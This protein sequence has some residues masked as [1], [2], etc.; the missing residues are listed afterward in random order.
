MTLTAQFILTTSN[1]SHD[2]TPRMAGPGVS[3]TY[4]QE[5]IWQGFALGEPGC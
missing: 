5:F 4:G 2:G 1:I 3:T